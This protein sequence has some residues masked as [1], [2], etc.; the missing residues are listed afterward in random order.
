MPGPG[1][2]HIDQP[3]LVVQQPPTILF[4]L[5]GGNGIGPDRV[6]LVVQPTLPRQAHGLLLQA[7]QVHPAQ[8]V[9]RVSSQGGVVRK[10][11]Q[12]HGISP[13]RH[14]HGLGIDQP[15]AGRAVVP[16]DRAVRRLDHRLIQGGL[17]GE[18]IALAAGKGSPFEPDHRHGIPLQTLGLVDGH[19]GHV[20]L[21]FVSVSGQFGTLIQGG[22]P[23]DE[24]AQTGP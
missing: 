19:Q 5:R 22:Q 20:G 12:N 18:P 11:W 13:H 16:V 1:R 9:L 14:R 2:S 8:Q 21:S 17:D 24:P 10:A 4:A 6:G 3:P 15:G 23:G 7:S